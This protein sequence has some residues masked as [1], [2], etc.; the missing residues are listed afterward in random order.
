MD[1]AL[2]RRSLLNLGLRSAAGAGILSIVPATELFEHF[3]GG[4]ALAASAPNVDTARALVCIYLF[5]DGDAQLAYHPGR[6]LHPALADLQP[7]YER[8]ALA[9]VAN[10]APATRRARIM[11]TP[12]DVMAH[13]Y[14]ALRF[15]PNGFATPE[16]AARR[17]DVKPITGEGA[18]TFASGVSLVAPGS[19]WLEGEQF[20]NATVR[21]TT[22]RLGPMRTSFPDTPIGRQLEDVS[23]LLRAGDALSMEAAGLPGRGHWVYDT[24]AARR[25]AGRALSRAES[26]HGR[27]LPCHGGARVGSAGHHVHRW[28]ARD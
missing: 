6:G 2:S 13:R 18:Y 8:K 5:G 1:K 11:Q 4:P 28:R 12:G 21:A 25:H 22:S 16:W 14:S 17:A 26:G 24:R 9:V 23:R 15:L 27:L 19:A 10:V 7:L 3:T 20:E